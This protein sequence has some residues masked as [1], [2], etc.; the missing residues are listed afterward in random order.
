MGSGTGDLTWE[1]LQAECQAIADG[2]FLATVGADGRPHVTYAGVGFGPEV[3]WVGIYRRSQK[4]RNLQHGNDVALHWPEDPERLIFGRAVARVVDDPDEKR[5]LWDGRV[6]PY[7][8]A[9]FY[10]GWDDRNLLYVELTP[11]RFTISALD[12]RVPHRR[13]RRPA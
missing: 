4:A 12:P 5:G 2:A 6:L 13:W 8:P 10:R 7:D 11:V 1:E 3:L 9:R